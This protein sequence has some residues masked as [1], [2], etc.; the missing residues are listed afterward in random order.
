MQKTMDS[1]EILEELIT[2][3]I[4][5]TPTAKKL[6]YNDLLRICKLVSGSLFD[7]NRCSMWK[8]KS[9]QGKST[10]INFYFKRKK[11]ALHR[12]LYSNFVD[13]L[14]NDEYLKFTCPNKGKCCTVTHLKKFQYKKKKKDEKKVVE[15][16]EKSDDTLES[17][18]I[19]FD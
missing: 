13:T 7:D 19:S 12:L 11:T 8:I 6:R 4:K 16:V 1:N 3:Q 15:T 5:N 14:S 2:K 9:E 18:N 10:Y 17:I